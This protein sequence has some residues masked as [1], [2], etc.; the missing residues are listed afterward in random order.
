MRRVNM[1]IGD[2]PRSDVEAKMIRFLKVVV[3]DLTVKRLR[4]CQR[5]MLKATASIDELE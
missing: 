4:S 5:C 2:P 3:A 1:V